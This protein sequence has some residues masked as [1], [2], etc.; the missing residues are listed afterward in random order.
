M[1]M[2]LLRHFDGARLA[3][4]HHL[5]VPRVLHLGLDALGD[6][7][8]EL[9]GVEVGDDVGLGHHA[10]LAPGLDRVAQLHALVGHRDLLELREALDVGLEH[11]APGARPRR[12]DAV[13]RLDQPSLDRL[14]LDVLVAAEGRVDDRRGFAVLGEHLQRQLRVAPLLLVRQRLADVVEQPHALGQLDV[15]L[16]LGRHHP[17][18]PGDLL[19]VLEAVLA[20]GSPELH[21]AHELDELGMQPVHPDL[22]TGL[23]P[24]VLQVLLHLQLDLLD[25]LLDAR[26]VDAAVGDQDLEGAPRDLPA[27]RVIGGD[28]DGL[29]RV[30]DD[31]IHA[32]VELERAD[33]A[34]LPA[35]DTPLHV[36]GR[37]VQYRDGRFDRVVGREAL[38]GRREDLLRLHVGD[39]AR[40]L[41]ES[42]G[43]QL[44]LAAR[45]RLDLGEELTL[46]LFDREPGDGLEL[47][48]LLLERRGEA[49]FLLAE[50]LLARDE[51]ALLRRRVVQPPVELIEL[52]REILLL[53][54]DALLDLLSLTL[55]PT[56]LL[57][58]LQA[59]L[60]GGLLD[61]EVG[62]LVTV[63]DF[64]LG[65]LDD[66]FG[67]ALSIADLALAEPL[68]EVEPDD[69]GEERNGGV[70]T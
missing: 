31:E 63:R 46:G 25:D 60:E 52:A 11:V 49:D 6:V 36:V 8:R 26:R 44:R 19:R 61:L 45:L 23:L 47:A 51:L 41:L 5:D 54:N 39:L 34:P 3:D 4:D 33:V 38:D 55:P 18:E 16:D 42:H 35:D 1:F 24:L 57:L 58:Q 67:A 29:G 50:R 59:P 70:E 48:P 65:V 30:V 9:V 7:L 22:E 28:Q 40:L 10:E 21:A 14:G 64:T 12:R 32:R 69:D 68:V 43:E 27:I 66:Q 37:Q 53:R 56:H 62:D 13:G 17:R 20:V 2:R 15:D